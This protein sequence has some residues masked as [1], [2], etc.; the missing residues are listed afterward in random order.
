MGFNYLENAPFKDSINTYMDA[1]KK[2]GF[3]PG[4]I[5][6]QVTDSCGYT[7]SSAVYAKISSPHYPSC[8]MDGIAVKA[9]DTFGAGETTPVILSSN[10]FVVV[11]TGDPLPEGMDS[12]IM[13]EEVIWEE[14]GAAKLTQVAT[15]WQHVRQIG[16][17]ICMGEMI[18]PSYTMIR[19]ATIGSM[20]A[21]GVLEISVLKKPV[22]GI[23]PT[24][25]EIVEPTSNPRPG[26][27][28]EFNS[29]IFA[30]MLE[31]WGAKSIKYPI[32]KDDQDSLKVAVKKALDECNI[33]LM[34][35]G[36]SAGRDDYTAST[37]GH[38]GEV[39]IHG[40][41]VRPGKP[42][43]LGLAGDKPIIGIPGYPVSG[44]VIMEQFVKDIIDLWYHRER[45]EDTF[46]T[47]KLSRAVLSGFKYLEKVR[48]R[49]GKVNGDWVASPLA[50]GAGVV[51]SFS[52]ADGI[53]DIPQ[54][55]EG[56]ASGE[57]VSVRLLRPIQELKQAVNVIGSHDPLLDEISD[58]LKKNAQGIFM[59]STHVGSMGG[60]MAV[61]KGECHIAAI[62]LLD[63]ND[64]E[65][66]VS[67]VNKYFPN[68]G[69]RLVECI[70]RTQGIMIAKGNPKGIKS[71]KDLKTEGIRY[72]NRQKG[73]GTRILF[74][75]LLGKE[76]VDS[77]EIYGYEREEM[78][79]MS[80]AA[81]IESGTA[82]AGMGIYSAAQ[83]Y[84]LDFIEICMEK[85]D[86]L[87]PDYAWE[88]NGVQKVIEILKS[89]EFKNRL[90][91]LGGYE[92]NEVVIRKF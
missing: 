89:A 35:A 42:A 8:A 63:E 56:Y 47:A 26:D 68:G 61:R 3:A 76:G 51:S 24:G 90:Q 44:I 54:D 48:V 37:I 6:I 49:L 71:V 75:Y 18:V 20:L 59:N 31:Q 72:V 78:T 39:V 80:V 52:K 60:I 58:I 57:K 34:N 91:M 21:G 62:H 40:I 22:V 66:N 74:D 79:H 9:S 32:V 36:S 84:G 38:F 33:V 30:S 12:V 92:I 65:Y 86:L 16:E 67:Y 17:D 41:A 77:K 53:V 43:V 5:Q 83:M 25:D 70:G 88:E 28:I 81:Q 85:Y 15:P 7:V 46:L 29:S 69:V 23:I 1:I 55:V 19:P 45:E 11:D 27:I 10:Q 4:T 87:I 13:I 50:R 2:S 73:A 82:D 14:K 64:G